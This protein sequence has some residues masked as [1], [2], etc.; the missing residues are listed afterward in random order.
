M[1][2]VRVNRFTWH[3]MICQAG[4]WRLLGISVDR[5]MWHSMICEDGWWRLRD[6]CQQVH[7]AQYDM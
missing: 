4:W 5:F 3:T 7:V 6:I 1:E 2:T